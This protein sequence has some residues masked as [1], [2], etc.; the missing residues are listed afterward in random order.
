MRDLGIEPETYEQ[1]TSFATVESADIVPG[2]SAHR[3]TSVP[4]H[5]STVR[6]WRACTGNV[7]IG[8]DSFDR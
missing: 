1:R 8:T 2:P 3:A 6:N 4:A 7:H 5:R